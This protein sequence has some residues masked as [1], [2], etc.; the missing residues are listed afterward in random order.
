MK[1]LYIDHVDVALC[2]H[3]AGNSLLHKWNVIARSRDL[4][5]EFSFRYTLR[6]NQNNYGILNISHYFPQY[7]E[8][9]II[10]M[11]AFLVDN[12]YG[13]CRKSLP[14]DSWHSNGYELCPS[15][16]RHLSAF[17]RSGIHSVF[18][19]LSTGKKQLASLFN[20]TYSY[21]DDVLSI[22]NPEFE[23][24]RGQLFPAELEI[25]D[26]TES[27][28][29]APY[30]DLLLS[31]WRDGQLHTSIYDKR[32]DFN[33]HIKN[34][35]FLSSNIPSSPAYDVFISQPIR[36]SRTCSLYECFILR[37]KRLSLWG[38]A[39]APIVETSFTEPAASF[40]D[41]SP[42][43]PLGTFSILLSVTLFLFNK[44]NFKRQIKTR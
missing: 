34:F 16:R 9:D 18:N 35:P 2:A 13:F 37:A 20:L 3:C 41:I 8:D 15:S 25:K 14:A 38:L 40:L 32:N 31:I 26:T 27:T 22:N 24:Y 44:R 5:K 30:L 29:S 17:I 6:P 12:I 1:H 21:I 43:I 28:T 10:K 11:L 36:Y 42:W 23:N 4:L 7:F 39:Y 33:Y 19:L